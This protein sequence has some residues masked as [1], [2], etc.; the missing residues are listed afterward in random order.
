MT[1]AQ[2]KPL[3]QFTSWRGSSAAIASRSWTRPPPETRP[4]LKRAYGLSGAS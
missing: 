1:D 4:P 2:I 3:T